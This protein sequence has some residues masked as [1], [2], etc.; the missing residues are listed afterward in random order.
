MNSQLH[1]GLTW[2][3]L[4]GIKGSFVA[5]TLYNCTHVLVHLGTA[6][7][8]AAHRWKEEKFGF[9]T[10]VKLVFSLCSCESEL[11][12]RSKVQITERFAKRTKVFMIITTLLP[13]LVFVI[14][15]HWRSVIDA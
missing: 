1:W 2:K 4:S 15:N 9:S 13:I 3:Q 7:V 11:Q 10:L 5:H 8:Q 12:E 6:V 14:G